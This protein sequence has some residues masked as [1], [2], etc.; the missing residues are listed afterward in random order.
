MVPVKNAFIKKAT[1]HSRALS[2]QRT[3]DLS[4]LVKMALQTST[5]P[6]RTKPGQ[7]LALHGAELYGDIDGLLSG[8]Q[9]QAGQV[10]I[11]QFVAI[12]ILH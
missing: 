10:R 6:T 12:L 11:S 7:G 1:K 3:I 5:I 4:E 2:R 8:A 9:V